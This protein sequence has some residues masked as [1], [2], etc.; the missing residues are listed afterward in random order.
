MKKLPTKVILIII[1]LALVSALVYKNSQDG[2]NYKTLQLNNKKITV[3]IADSQTAKQKGLSGRSYLASDHG[4]LFPFD[5]S[6][7]YI[8]WMKDM[9][10]D[11]D[12][13]FVNNGF[14]VQVAENVPHPQNNEEPQIVKSDVLSDAVIEVNSGFVKDYNI[15]IGDEVK[16]G[17]KK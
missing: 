10:F 16:G 17:D 13:I 9:A 6:G 12:F 5:K 1:F 15:K 3:E 8:F 2:Q 7:Y 14:I 11:L 4:M